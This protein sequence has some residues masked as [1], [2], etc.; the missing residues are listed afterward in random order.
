MDN[1]KASI[2]A[3]FDRDKNFL[4]ADPD[5][6][7]QTAYDN[8]GANHLDINVQIQNSKDVCEG[9]NTCLQEETAQR[10]ISKRDRL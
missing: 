2:S 5:L 3:K 9:I 8:S 10:T 6:H 7:D 1:S 4:G